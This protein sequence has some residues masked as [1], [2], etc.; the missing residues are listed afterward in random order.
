MLKMKTLRAEVY[1]ELKVK[2]HVGAWDPKTDFEG[3]YRQAARESQQKLER[4]LGKNG[5]QVVGTPGVM[6]VSISERD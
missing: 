1:I 4:V 6:S 3:L 2:V 5:C